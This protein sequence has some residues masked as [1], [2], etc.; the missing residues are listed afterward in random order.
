LQCI[1]D[2]KVRDPV[3]ALGWLAYPGVSYSLF[4]PYENELLS[5]VSKPGFPAQRNRAV[6]QGFLLF[7]KCS[8]VF[9]QPFFCL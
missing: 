7:R 8:S 5:T 4:M 6:Y 1:R 2:V 9:L 3:E